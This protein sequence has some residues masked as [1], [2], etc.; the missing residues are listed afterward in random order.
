MT[1][2]IDNAQKI[3]Q[4]NPAF[5]DV[6]QDFA[7]GA[8]DTGNLRVVFVSSDF[9]VLTHMEGRSEWSRCLPVEIGEADVG[10]PAAIAYL[11]SKMGWTADDNA[12]GESAVRTRQRVEGRGTARECMSP[13]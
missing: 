7:K 4:R 12:A 11:T 5:L 1:L 10:E 3:V 8:A 13:H 6:L 2:V 9:A